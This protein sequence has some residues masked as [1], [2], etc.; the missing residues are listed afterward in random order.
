MITTFSTPVRD[1]SES[2]AVCVRK[3]AESYVMRGFKARRELDIYH[4]ILAPTH[5]CNLRCKHCYLPNHATQMLSK[6]VVFRQ[7]L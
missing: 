6:D 4:L 5:A 3:S 7:H 1:A 2:P